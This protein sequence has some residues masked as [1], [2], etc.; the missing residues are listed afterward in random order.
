MTVLK[1]RLAKD[2]LNTQ[3]VYGKLVKCLGVY[4]DIKGISP[5][6]FFFESAVFSK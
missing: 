3:K 6:T 1:K 2:A 4:Y 5:V